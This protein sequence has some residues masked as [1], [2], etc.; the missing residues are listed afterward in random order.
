MMWLQNCTVHGAF[1]EGTRAWTGWLL[2]W[3]F[4]I[5]TSLGKGAREQKNIAGVLAFHLEGWAEH[6]GGSAFRS[7]V[8][9]EP[10]ISKRCTWKLLPV[11]AP[12]VLLWSNQ[13][14]STYIKILKSGLEFRKQTVKYL[15]LNVKHLNRCY[16]SFLELICFKAVWARRQDVRLQKHKKTLCTLTY[17][18]ATVTI[19]G[20]SAVSEQNWLPFSKMGKVADGEAA[21][22]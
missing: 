20:S 8:L 22:Y 13:I 17:F 6:K 18:L 4:L 7:N 3:W 5:D 19:S 9:A 10:A 1:T 16:L 15:I 2:G 14:Q 12:H 11:K 21:R